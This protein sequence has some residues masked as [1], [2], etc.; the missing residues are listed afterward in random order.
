MDRNQKMWMLATGGLTGL[1]AV[2][3]VRF[4]NPANMGFCIAC[5]LRDMAGSM[6]LHQAAVVQYMRPEIAGLI[7]G[8]FIMSV[9]SKEYQSKGGSSP[10]T[11]FVLGILVMIGALMFLGCPL[12]MVLRLA[13][14]DLNAIAGLLGFV[15][16]IGIGIFF[17]QKG[18]SLRRTYVQN[19][20][21]GSMMTILISGF[22]IAS[23]A[24][25]LWFARSTSGPGASAAPW[26]LALVV[27]GILGALAYKT[28]LCTVGGIRDAVMF[29]D[30]HLL[31]GFLAIFV[32]AL[33]ANLVNGTFKIGWTGQPIA[34]TDFLWNAMGM[35]LVGFASALLGGCPLRQLI[36][37]GGGNSD[38]AITIFGLLVG[39]AISHNWGLASSAAGPTPAGKIAVV[40]GLII[41]LL[42]ALMNRS[43][44]AQ[45]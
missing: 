31:S 5:F 2:L 3:L 45:K 32:F 43:K 20:M 12:R 24:V 40:A 22:F 7:L 6:K 29:R 37:A 38:S 36:L 4:G 26:L 41:T 39:A 23:L 1:F 42:I 10:V 9:A 13:G 33:V 34:H 16:G 17:L 15:V 30:F 14:G 8:A 18:F 25:P 44:G 28:R 27:G 11:R 35:V 21:E 19:P